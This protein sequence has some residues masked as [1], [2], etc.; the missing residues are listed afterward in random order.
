VTD[1]VPNLPSRIP[2]LDGLRAVSIACVILE[3]TAISHSAP[4]LLHYFDHL[5]NLGVRCFFIISGFLITTLLL[6]ERHNTG[7][8]ALKNFFARRVIRIFPAAYTLI[9][10]LAII[11]AAGLISLS[12][13][14]FVHAI[15]YTMN[16][17]YTRSLWLDHLWS[18]SVEEQFYLVWPGLLVL[19]GSQSGFRGAWAV[20]LT[21]PVVRAIMWF[22]FG[23]TD[24]AMT[25]H[26]EAIADALATGCLLSAYYN[27]LAYYNWY[28][29]FQNSL[30][31]W[32]VALVLVGTGNAIFLIR[33]WIFYVV[34]QTVA[35]IGT[36]L[37]IDWCIRYPKARVGQMMNT[38]VLNYIGKI[39]YS[40]YLW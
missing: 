31:F 16:Y 28:N 33:P 25:K 38:R 26:F 19:V 13:G 6:K 40:L 34:G 24:T 17:H 39:S 27:R 8:I 7:R 30:L 3:H 14:D 1:L 5:G 32:P 12:P 37:C 22:W 2:S 10:I 18:L 15:T 23:A 35:N 4:P 36:A 21:A 11:H 20:M 9:G 29:R